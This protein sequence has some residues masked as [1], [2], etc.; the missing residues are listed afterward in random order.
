MKKEYHVC[1][2]AYYE[3]GNTTDHH[4]S[5]KLA[6]IPKWIEAYMYT[7]PCMISLSIKVWLTDD[8]KAE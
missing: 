8:Q 5:M 2:R 1:F 3:N 7:H 6:E 4:R